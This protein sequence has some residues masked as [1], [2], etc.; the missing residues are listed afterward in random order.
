MRF[1][2]IGLMI[3]LISC[4]SKDIIHDSEVVSDYQTN[5]SSYIH[6]DIKEDISLCFI[7]YDEQGQL[8][9]RKGREQLENVIK[10]I[11]NRGQ[12]QQIFIYIHGW[13]HN[14]QN[15]DN[16]VKSFRKFLEKVKK[17]TKEKVTGIYIGWRGNS[18]KT[19]NQLITLPTFWNRK[20]ISENIGHGSIL[21]FLLRI[22]EISNKT[23]S[24]LVTIGH[25]LG[26]SVLYTVLDPILRKRF[27]DFSHNHKKLRGFGDM[28]ILYNP[29]IEA[30]RANALKEMLK[31]Y[32]SHNKQPFKNQKNPIL[33]VLSGKKDCAT[34]TIFPLGRRISTIFTTYS[35]KSGKEKDLKSLSNY[36]PFITHSIE[37]YDS[38]SKYKN[39]ECDITS[40]D[41]FSLSKFKKQNTIIF[42]NTMIDLKYIGHS[43]PQ[44]P[45]WFLYDNGDSI[46]LKHNNLQNRHTICLL[47]TL[48]HNVQQDKE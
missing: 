13:K 24:S 5:N 22:E 6:G 44:N 28:V 45:Y 8:F 39:W 46:I 3:F 35:N 17:S 4:A 16:N 47:L 29:A 7:E 26:A 21:E 10:H 40:E 19:S 2:Y 23:K 11:K 9:E 43:S 12:N 15:S 32:E 14:S 1:L 34:N 30:T 33:I 27:I 25:S 20:D 38:I 41:N 37:A 18:L 36:K 48:I 31:Y 42:K